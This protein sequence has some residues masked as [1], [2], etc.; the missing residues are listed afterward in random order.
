M[1]LVRLVNLECISYETALL[2]RRGLKQSSW[3]TLFS[4]LISEVAYCL[5]AID[6][7][8]SV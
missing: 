6:V 8:K 3:S 7:E 4:D 5:V 2:K 1:L